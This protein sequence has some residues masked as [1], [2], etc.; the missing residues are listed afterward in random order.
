MHRIEINNYTKI[1]ATDM[2]DVLSYLF[3]LHLLICVANLACN[4]FIA[5]FLVLFLFYF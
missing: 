5:R 1:D 3:T 2:N 4:W